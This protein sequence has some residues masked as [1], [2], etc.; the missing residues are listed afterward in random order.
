MT[1]VVLLQDTRVKIRQK[2]FDAF[3]PKN[4]GEVIDF[5]IKHLQEESPELIDRIPL[6]GLREMVGNGI[7]R[8]RSHSLGSLADLTG[9]VSI[10]FEIAPNFDVIPAIRRVL[11]DESAPPDKRFS[12]LFEK[13]LDE[14]WERAANNFNAETWAEAWFPELRDEQE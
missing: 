5:I 3:S 13:E 11:R 9:F 10:M 2:Q 4:D 14:A 8:A 12:M 1:L 6:D 7:A